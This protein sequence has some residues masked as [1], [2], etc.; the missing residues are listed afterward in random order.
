MR[1]RDS[2]DA[3]RAAQVLGRQPTVGRFIDATME[4]LQSELGDGLVTF[5]ELNLAEG[6][7][8][9]SL[10]P[11]LEHHRGAVAELKG[12]LAEH[13]MLSWYTTQPD[14][15]P[16]RISD[17]IDPQSLRASRIYQ[18]VLV[19]VG[20]QH[21]V[22]ISVTAPLSDTWLYFMANRAERDFDDDE[23]EFA[24]R[25]QPVLVAL[26][27]SLAGDQSSAGRAQVRVTRRELTVLRLVAAGHTADRI[28]HELSISRATVRK[29]LENLYR[30]LGTTDRLGAV[31]QA[32]DLGLLREDEVSRA[33]H[34]D[35]WA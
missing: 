24:R 11:Y 22:L 7:A 13:P 33:F 19:P 5:N 27:T 21:A 18:E 23:L 6:T 2:L 32:R 14:W 1:D 9:V 35:V 31:I 17:L 8:T 26:Y 4:L 25:L 10:R 15:S 30:K 29:H 34:W 3:L 16:V 12:I 20:G 28:S